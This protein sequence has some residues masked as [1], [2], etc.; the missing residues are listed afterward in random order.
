MELISRA[1]RCKRED[2]RYAYVAPLLGQAKEIAWPYLTRFANPVLTQPPNQSELWVEVLGGARI[3]IHGADNPDRLRG[4]YLDGIILDEFADMQP[5]LW[6]EV[7][8]PMLADRRGFAVF[9]GTPKGRNSFWQIVETAGHF[10]DRWFRAIM[11]AS[12]TGILNWFELEDAR[13]DMTEEQFAQE[14]ECSFDAAIM[15]SYYGKAIAEAERQG[16]IATAGYDPTLA[17]HCAWDLGIGDSTSI[18]FAQFAGSE[19]RLIDFYENNAQPLSHYA[20][21]LASKGYRYGHDFVPHDARVREW[22][23]G[24]T[25]VE[26]MTEHGRKPALVPDHKVEDGINAVRVVLPRCWFDRSRCAVGL[27][28]LRQYRADFNEKK[29]AFSDRPRHDWSSHAADAFRY[30]CMAWRRAAKPAPATPTPVLKG[31]NQ[32]TYDELWES[33]DGTPDRPLRYERI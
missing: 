21:V 24:K 3:R 1:L 30:L 12:E 25:R 4:M 27:E 18:W 32:T 11:P 10:P 33:I 8:R 19:I 9:I 16:R 14:F 31:L 15:G 26:T 6:G 29:R 17:V 2:G 23:T 22:G 13:R 5:S 20:E 7:V 28:A